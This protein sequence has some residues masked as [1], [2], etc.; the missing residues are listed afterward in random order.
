MSAEFEKILPLV[1]RDYG[2]LCVKRYI[3]GEPEY[4]PP[5]SREPPIRLSTDREDAM[6]VAK[7]DRLHEND[8]VWMFG[9]LSEEIEAALKSLRDMPSG[10]STDDDF[11]RMLMDK[12]ENA[13]TRRKKLE[14]VLLK[15]YR[16]ATP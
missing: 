15:K 5:V 4:A 1:M 10:T 16:T 9:K 7:F 11:F 8:P 13:L 12:Y 6:R 3:A 2:D 14:P